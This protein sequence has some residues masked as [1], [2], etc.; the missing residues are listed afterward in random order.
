[1]KRSSA[2]T[3]RKGRPARTVPNVVGGLAQ[4]LR[5]FGTFS[6]SEV[7]APAIRL[8]GESVKANATTRRAFSLHRSRAF[9]DECFVFE[10]TRD[11]DLLF[12]SRS[13]P[14]PW[15]VWLRKGLSGFTPAP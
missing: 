10:E 5:T 7:S 6:W 11:G 4:A 1:M 8:A 9:I 2:C 15:S 14:E 13:S 12:G 3:P